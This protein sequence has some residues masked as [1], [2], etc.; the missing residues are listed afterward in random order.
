MA[1]R[2]P[3]EI[4]GR[5]VGLYNEA[6][7][8]NKV[9]KQLGIGSTTVFRVLRENGVAVA[10]PSTQ[11]GRDIRS[12]ICRSEVQAVADDYAAGMS[13]K[14]LVEKYKVGM[15]AVRGAVRRAGTPLRGRG[16][17][18]KGLSDEEKNSIKSLYVDEGL[19]QNAIALRLGCG[20]NVINRILRSMGVKPRLRPARGP[21][22]GN[23]KGGR[24]KTSSGYTNIIVD[25]CDPLFVMSDSQGYALEHRLVMARAMGRPLW[26]YETVHHINGDK[27][28]NRLENLQLRSG[29]H[30][31]GIVMTCEE[32]GSHNIRYRKLATV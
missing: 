20:L 31:N 5:I 8:G 10:A 11:A 26:P 9:A 23:W 3:D 24:V 12:K 30:G 14:E 1:L 29:N 25:S 2:L 4:R 22:H 7:S 27:T 32:C 21:R 16:G 13:S 28:D 15:H 6:R 19:S 18:Y 17:R